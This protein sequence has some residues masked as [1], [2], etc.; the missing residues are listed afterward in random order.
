MG[1]TGAI[2]KKCMKFVWAKAGKSAVVPPYNKK[3]ILLRDGGV[4]IMG[5]S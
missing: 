2:S 5:S 3:S 1:A 4:F